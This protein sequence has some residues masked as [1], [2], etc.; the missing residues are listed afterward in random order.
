MTQAQNIN[1]SDILPYLHKNGEKKYGNGKK[2]KGSYGEKYPDE[3][4]YDDDHQYVWEIRTDKAVT[5]K[6]RYE[7]LCQG[8][9]EKKK[10]KG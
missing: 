3:G 5:D 2:R 8:K 9:K 7:Y 10:Y 1:D 4:I 6:E